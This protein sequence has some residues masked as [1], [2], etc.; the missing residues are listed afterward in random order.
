MWTIIGTCMQCLTGHTSVTV[1]DGQI[2]TNTTCEEVLKSEW[3][4]KKNAKSITC[5]IED[6]PEK[7][8]VV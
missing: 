1:Y 7:E 6:V 2:S 3:I 4:P 8:Q 5:G